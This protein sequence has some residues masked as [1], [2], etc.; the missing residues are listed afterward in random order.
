MLNIGQPAGVVL[1][2]GIF[3]ESGSFSHE[4]FLVFH[5]GRFDVVIPQGLKVAEGVGRLVVLIVV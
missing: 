3:D 5:V 2:V 4:V 1:A